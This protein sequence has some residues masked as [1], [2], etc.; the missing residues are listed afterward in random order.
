M[1]SQSYHMDS[2]IRSRVYAGINKLASLVAATLGP[3]GRTVL[4]ERPDQPPLATKDGV[5]VARH[6]SASGDIE[7]IVAD[8][9]KE[10]CERTVRSAGD[11]TTTAIVLANALTKAGVEWLEA[12]PQ[13]SPQRLCRE[14]NDIYQAKIKPEILRLSRP[15]KSLSLEE[16]KEAARHVALISANHDE[17]IAKAVA[18]AVEYVGE[19]GMIVAEEG[20]GAETRVEHQD[21]F[22]FNS[23]L[24]DLGG[25]AAASF[26]N[27]QDY[28]DC[29]VDGAYVCLYDGDINDPGTIA[30][31]LQR[32]ASELGDDGRPVRHPIVVFAHHF[33]DG[34]LKM[35][36]QNFR[37]G[38]LTVVPVK[39][40]RNGQANGRSQFLFDLRAYVGGTVFDPQGRSVVEAHISQLGFAEKVK[41][42]RSDGLILGEP[43]QEDVEQRIA[44]LKKQME[45]ASEFDCDLLRYRIGRLTGGVAQ[46]FAGG[47]TALESRER[48]ARVVDAISAVRSAMDSGVVPGGGCTLAWISHLFADTTGPEQIYWKSLGVPF[49]QILEN[50]GV[51]N[52]NV[53]FGQ[54][55]DGFMVYDALKQKSVEWWSAG[56]LDPAKVTITALEN[57]L[58]VSKQ[59]MTLGGIICQEQTEGAEQVKAIQAGLQKAIEE[60]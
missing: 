36:S 2:T 56:I 23:G 17:E 5:T 48:H 39:T 6:F 29:V 4:I 32:V 3:G 41:L 22:S 53:P 50:A 19:D 13:Y 55:G 15:I 51:T 21:G 10:V 38:V 46:V 8:S 40:P 11:G 42:M 27:R 52:K 28:G 25:P 24:S 20:A 35:F 37:R 30:P 43:I 16:A 33:S 1:K 60:A 44:D 31:L 49:T 9:A 34:V 12:H 57:A 54:I 18:E 59:L 45:G 26:I 14:L 58:S 7:R 47:A